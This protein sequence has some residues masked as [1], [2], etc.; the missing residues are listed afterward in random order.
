MLSTHLIGA[1]L[2]ILAVNNAHAASC[3]PA[4]LKESA[5][6]I[7]AYE[8]KNDNLTRPLLGT[9]LEVKPLKVLIPSLKSDE[10]GE[11]IAEVDV[12]ATTQVGQQVIETGRVTLKAFNDDIQTCEV[13]VYRKTVV[14]SYELCREI[15][16]YNGRIGNAYDP[17]VE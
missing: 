9:Q 5:K 13:R 8:L 3:D 6:T 15:K 12:V 1:L 7:A 17:C 16:G 4:K 11:A 10:I 2:L 14:S